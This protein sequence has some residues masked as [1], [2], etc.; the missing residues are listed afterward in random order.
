MEPDGPVTSATL[1]Q[2]CDAPE[3]GSDWELHDNMTQAARDIA[4]QSP[5]LKMMRVISHTF[6]G[7]ALIAKDCIT[8]KR[9]KIPRADLEDDGDTEDEDSE[10]TDNG[11]FDI[12]NSSWGSESE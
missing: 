3:G 6:P 5:D 9:L 4:V 10:P 8:G 11:L 12:D 7:L 2:H 1:S